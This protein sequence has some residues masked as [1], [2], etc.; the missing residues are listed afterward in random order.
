MILKKSSFIS[1]VLAGGLAT[2]ALAA[3][4]SYDCVANPALDKPGIDACLLAA[5]ADG[6]CQLSGTCE[7]TNL[8]SPIIM[9]AANQTLRGPATIH[10][11]N[12]TAIALR[13]LSSGSTI[14]DLTI[15]T[16]AGTG[17]SNT[18][19]PPG[20]RFEQPDD[21]TIR[22]NKITAPRPIQQWNDNAP[23]L[24]DCD[25]RFLPACVPGGLATGW[26]IEENTI[27]SNS[28]NNLGLLLAGSDNVLRNNH[29]TAQTTGI[30]L[31]NN[32][33]IGTLSLP[34]A[35][36]NY[37]G[38]N[39]VVVG[40]DPARTGTNPRG[41]SLFGL[42]FAV[43]A[44]DTPGARASDNVG[45]HNCLEVFDARNLFLSIALSSQHSERNE[46]AKTNATVGGA[47]TTPQ[48]D[49]RF[50]NTSDE[51]DSVYSKN[52]IA[53]VQTDGVLIFDHV[54]PG[55]PRN[56]LVEHTKI[57]PSINPA[58]AFQYIAYSENTD[59]LNPNVF[60]RNKA[61]NGLL[62][63]IPGGTVAFG[64]QNGH[65]CQH[66][67]DLPQAHDCGQG[68]GFAGAKSLELD[69]TATDLVEGSDRVPQNYLDSPYQALVDGSTDGAAVQAGPRLTTSGRRSR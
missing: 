13:A 63:A 50:T 61:C 18:T 62:V 28:P 7:I 68:L 59:A 42:N 1:A 38:H 48:G 55:P 69:G 44:L 56:E 14:E 52:D 66:L 6:T 15:L 47:A 40:N 31:Q 45:E 21:I 33:G 5:G 64:N 39:V 51:R 12:G 4:A 41:I 17:I 43:P 25:A 3:N 2:G 57:G 24:N 32:L 23:P 26:V 60:A 11:A 22:N 10:R 19:R 53:G 35:K 9:D 67:G 58:Y 20:A 27:V 37:L 49:D 54:L 34:S 30:A 65:Y 29:V 8:V 36:R 46:W 16:E